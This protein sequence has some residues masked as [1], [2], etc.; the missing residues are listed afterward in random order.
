[1]Q[2]H[3]SFR[4]FFSLKT[5]NISTSSEENGMY[6]LSICSSNL[7]E[8]ISGSIFARYA[9]GIEKN[10][11]LWQKTRFPMLNLHKGFQV[12]HGS[13]EPIRSEHLLSS[14][15]THPYHYIA[16][17]VYSLVQLVHGLTQIE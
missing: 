17:L 10:C 6:D 12:G 3:P 2:F 14:L 1:M 4:V 9:T 7:Q 11:I 8:L 5:K 13:R 15:S 16:S